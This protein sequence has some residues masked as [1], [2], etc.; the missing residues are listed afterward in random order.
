MK[1]FFGDQLFLNSDCAVALYNTVKDLPIIDYHCHL[2]Q[3]MIAKDATFNDIGELWLAG[4]HYKWR[5]MRINGVNE[6]YITGNKSFHDKF[7]KY[8][9]I[10]PNLIGNPLY[11][12][13]HLELKQIFGIDKPLNSDT[14]EE[15]YALANQKLKTLSVEK[16]LKFFNVEF[17]ATTDD[18]IDELSDHGKYGDTLVTP[19]FRPDKLY[20]LGQDYIDKLSCASGVEIN[21]LED[22]KTALCKRL[23][24]FLQK[25]CVISDHGFDRFPEEYAEKEQAEKYFIN[26]ASLSE[27]ERQALVG[28]ILVWLTK[29]YKKRG[30]IMQIHFAVTRNVNPEGFIRSG[31]DSG[32]DVM[33]ETPSVKN[34]LNY[35]QQVSDDDRPKTVLY[36]LNDANLTSIACL[37]GAFRNVVMG[38]AWWFNDTVE[39]IKRNLSI[40]AEYSGLGNNLGMLTDSRS[41]SS[42]C[43]FDFF[44]RILCDYVGE[45]VDKGEYDLENAKVLVKNICYNNVKKA[46][47]NG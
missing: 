2:D 46:V 36:T 7:I 4:D 40:I 3:K 18:P 42:Y 9:Q 5:A 17:I 43:R 21:T 13:T 34:L 39:G 37:S 22:L 47:T 32:Y 15:I 14:A 25:G 8:A 10:L 38:A 44:R 11:Y 31:V 19:T 1:K 24:Y 35:F 12:W 41:F 29:E 23:D 16:I 30:M 20:A 28:H 27:K 6:E 26:R 45:K 33:S